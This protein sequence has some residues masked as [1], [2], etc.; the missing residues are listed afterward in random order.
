MAA[1]QL[2]GLWQAPSTPYTSIRR[3]L[4]VAGLQS[5]LLLSLGDSSHMS[6]QVFIN[7]EVVLVFLSDSD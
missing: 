6:A 5:V 1:P 3:V 4:S 2:P 7:Y